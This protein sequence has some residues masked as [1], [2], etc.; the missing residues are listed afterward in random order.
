MRDV[1]GVDRDGRELFLGIGGRRP[2][3]NPYFR[4]V[5]RVNLDTARLT[6]LSSGDGD[7]LVFSPGDFTV[8]ILSAQGMDPGR[9]SGLSPGAAFFVETRQRP[10]RPN[11]TALMSA[12]GEER[13]IL[14]EGT[15]NALPD[16][17]RW[18]EPFS[19]TAADGET[20]IRA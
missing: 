8:L 10:D 7:R 19:V 2:G 12:D 20:E 15:P 4:E 16:G 3:A 5:A 17:Q 13:M 6:L 14:E 18:P 11:V 1:L 9:V